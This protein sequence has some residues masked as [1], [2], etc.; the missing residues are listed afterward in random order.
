MSL[1]MVFDD[2]QGFHH[3][4]KKMLQVIPNSVGW[5]PFQPTLVS[6]GHFFFTISKKGTNSQNCQVFS[7]VLMITA[8][9]ICTKKQHKKRTLRT[10]HFSPKSHVTG[11]GVDEF[12]RPDEW[13]S[14]GSVFN[15]LKGVPL[16]FVG[17]M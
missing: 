1:F 17:D 15:R 16:F 5:S 11:H 13:G 8:P 3:H 6:K 2:F 4:P 10:V 9:T 14:F 12:W 7:P